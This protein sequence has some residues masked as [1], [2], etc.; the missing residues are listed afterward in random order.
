MSVFSYFSLIFLRDRA[1]GDS[2]HRPKEAKLLSKPRKIASPNS[3]TK[4]LTHTVEVN[5]LR[6]KKFC[7]LTPFKNHLVLKSARQDFKSTLFV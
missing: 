6:G 7:H 2:V 1:Q 5:V 3:P 4:I